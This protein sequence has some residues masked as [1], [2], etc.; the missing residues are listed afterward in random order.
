ML[1]QPMEFFL[2]SNNFEERFLLISDE[3][4]PL[5]KP[6]YYVSDHGNMYSYNKQRLMNPTISHDGY[7]VC[8][9]RTFDGRG[10]T[11][12]IHRMEMLTFKYEPGCE[13]LDI[14]HV[15]C[16]KLNNYITNLEWVTTA[17]NT[18]RAAKNGL[19]LCGED[20]SWTKVTNQ[21]VH[22]ICKLYV[23]GYGIT[24]IARIIGCGLDSVFRV[25]HG[26]GR[27]DISSQY[28]IESKYRGYFTDE[29]IHLICSIFSNS[30]GIKY[31]DIKSYIF[32]ILGLKMNRNIDSIIRNLYRHDPY[33]YY[34]I[35]SLYEY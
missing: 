3:I 25:V 16:N 27:T 6:W 7:K 15:D 22:E 26:I 20:A 2:N 9:V 13:E 8:T 12:Y 1:F 28:D 17:E 34:R 32:D 19:L 4:I 5:I 23:S 11:V 14:D 29:Q 30:K 21:E 24:S 33:C 10:I 31:A 18:R 35:S